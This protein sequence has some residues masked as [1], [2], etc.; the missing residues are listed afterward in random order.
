MQALFAIQ[1]APYC[2]PNL[3]YCRLA[4]KDRYS[5]PIGLQ[6]VIEFVSGLRLPTVRRPRPSP[7]KHAV[8]AA[9]RT[10]SSVVAG[11]PSIT[12][13][14]ARDRAFQ[15]H[16]NVLVDSELLAAHCGS[17]GSKAQPEGSFPTSC[18]D[19]VPAIE[20]FVAMLTP[21]HHHVDYL[22][23]VDLTVAFDGKMCTATNGTLSC[24]VVLGPDVALVNY[25]ATK[26]PHAGMEGGCVHASPPPHPTTW[27][28]RYSCA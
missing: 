24:V 7:H 11:V 15:A 22:R 18:D 23:T 12:V 8:A 20:R 25:Q 21:T 5:F 19:G 17:H 9:A 13:L 14:E 27:P 28:P 6:H 4:S 3:Q 26:V 2:H 1:L 16:V 10:K